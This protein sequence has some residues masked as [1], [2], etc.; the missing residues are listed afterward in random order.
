MLL[1]NS[2]TGGLEVYDINSN[3][4]TNAAFIRRQQGMAAALKWRDEQF[5]PYE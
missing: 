3:Q 5:A 2:N 1:R 4:I